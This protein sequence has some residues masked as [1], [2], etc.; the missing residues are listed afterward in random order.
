M[1]L[2]ATDQATLRQALC[3]LQRAVLQTILDARQQVNQ[4][5]LCTISDHTA[6]AVIYAI[7]TTAEKAIHSWFDANWPAA[8]SVQIIMEGLDD[9]N[10]LCL[11]ARTPIEATKLK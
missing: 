4:E 3:D 11:P 9:D 1:H 5:A 2:T 8:W 10:T 7:D 6:A